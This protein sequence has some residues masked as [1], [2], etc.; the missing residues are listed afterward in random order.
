MKA[1]IYIMA[2]IACCFTCLQPLKAQDEIKFTPVFRSSDV[3]AASASINVLKNK[4]KNQ[5]IREGYFSKNVTRFLVIINPNKLDVQT[6][7]DKQVIKFNLQF[8]IYDLLADQ[9]FHSFSTILGGVGKTEAQAFAVAVDRLNL[10]NK[11]YDVEFKA[12]IKKIND[13]YAQNCSQ[14]LTR[15][16]SL[17]NAGEYTQAFAQIDLIPNIQDGGCIDRYNSI[18]ARLWKIYNTHYCENQ[19]SKANLIWSTN[20]TIEG[21]QEAGRFLQGIDLNGNCKDSFQQLAT[22]IREK[23]INDQFD[24]K[25][26]RRMVLSGIV[27]IE[28]NKLEAIR[29]ITSSYYNRLAGDTYLIIP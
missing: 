17:L 12:A 24:E 25:E 10:A 1:T 13:Y 27:E 2:F 3:T 6:L 28:K 29:D 16:E 14:I 9:I 21:A 5:T 23:L 15:A 11:N 20:P 18:F 4:F 22:G 19:I 26:W 8:E 7:A